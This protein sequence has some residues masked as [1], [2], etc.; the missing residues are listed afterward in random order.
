MVIIKVELDHPVKATDLNDLKAAIKKEFRD[1]EPKAILGGA[2]V[3]EVDYDFCNLGLV[4]DWL[5]KGQEGCWRKAPT[6][7]TSEPARPV[8]A[9]CR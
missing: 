6:S 1:V 8:P 2:L 3:M 5:W 9:P 4:L 7:S